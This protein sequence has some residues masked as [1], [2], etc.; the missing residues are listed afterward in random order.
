MGRVRVT[1]HPS[2]MVWA[3][4]DDT[5]GAPGASTKPRSRTRP[6]ARDRRHLPCCQVGQAN[7]SDAEAAA[8]GKDT[9]E[10]PPHRRSCPCPSAR[11]ARK[12]ANKDRDQLLIGRRCKSARAHGHAARGGLE[13]R[14]RCLEGRRYWLGVCSCSSPRSTELR[15]S[16]LLRRTQSSTCTARFPWSVSSS[17]LRSAPTCTTRS[18]VRPCLQS[19]RV[20]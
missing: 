4:S 8:P 2:R 7:G 9:R 5:L 10:H 18:R 19:S 14:S 16:Q 17:F 20:A 1:L 15:H 13:M 11:Q 3:C 6:H 12:A